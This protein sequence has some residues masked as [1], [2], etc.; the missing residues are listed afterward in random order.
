MDA[1]GALRLPKKGEKGMDIVVRAIY[2]RSSC[3]IRALPWA[4][5]EIQLKRRT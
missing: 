3:I 5:V 4:V 2:S 1:V